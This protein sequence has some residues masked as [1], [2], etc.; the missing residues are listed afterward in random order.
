MLVPDD[1]FLAA[2][3]EGMTARIDPDPLIAVAKNT[4]WWSKFSFWVI[5]AAIVLMASWWYKTRLWPN[6][7]WQPLRSDLETLLNTTNRAA[8]TH[9]G[10]AQTSPQ[11]G[12]TGEEIASLRR[13]MVECTQ[14]ITEEICVEPSSRDF[15]YG[16]SNCPA[17]AEQA[18]KLI[19]S[20]SR[21][22]NPCL[23]D[24]EQ[25]SAILLQGQAV[26]GIYTD[27]QQVLK[28][29]TELKEAQPRLSFWA[30]MGVLSSKEIS[31][32]KD[33]LELSIKTMI[34]GLDL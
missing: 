17:L 9:L 21:S 25:C 24:Q 10:S 11:A 32:R 22:S 33:L 28:D 18:S 20:L 34:A 12:K 4:R 31:V 6:P 3:L 30:R 29:R 8:V 19:D 27:W 2:D 5:F 13:Q 16:F 23:E 26:H 14:Y 1:T 15:K 7:C